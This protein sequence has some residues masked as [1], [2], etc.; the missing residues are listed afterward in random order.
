MAPTDINSYYSTQEGTSSSTY[1]THRLSNVTYWYCSINKYRGRKTDASRTIPR[2]PHRDSIQQLV[3][4]VPWPYPT[5]RSYPSQEYLRYNLATHMNVEIRGDRPNRNG[6]EHV[7]PTHVNC[8]IYSTYFWIA[9]GSWYNK[10]Y[11]INTLYINSFVFFFFFNCIGSIDCVRN[12]VLVCYH[13]TH[14]YKRWQHHS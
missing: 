9:S 4:F 6:I 5:I 10:N 1:W 11:R 12:L 13:D 8:W 14:V 7:P 3:W 2:E